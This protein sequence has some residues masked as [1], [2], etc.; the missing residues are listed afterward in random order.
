MHLKFPKIFYET[1]QNQFILQNTAIPTGLLKNPLDLVNSPRPWITV[2]QSLAKKDPIKKTLIF[3]NHF[4]KN[5]TGEEQD[6]IIA[7]LKR[8]RM[9]NF[10][11]LIL[12]PKGILKKWEDGYYSTRL[13]NRISI[14]LRKKPFLNSATNNISSPPSSL[15]TRLFWL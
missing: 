10:K 12:L 8:A 2:N 3:A 13:C 7:Q 9:D 4:F 6:K 15:C 11:V 1:D 14:N 5:R